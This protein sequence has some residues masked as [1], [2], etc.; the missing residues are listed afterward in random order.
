MRHQIWKNTHTET[1]DGPMTEL[2]DGSKL[3][4]SE[5]VEFVNLDRRKNE[6][7]GIN[8]IVAKPR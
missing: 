8:D 2:H 5:A 7:V 6:T 1:L 4:L 3:D